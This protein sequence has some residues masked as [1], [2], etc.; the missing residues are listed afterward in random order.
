MFKNTN[1]KES[2]QKVDFLKINYLVIMYK[3]QYSYQK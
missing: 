1:K 2:L 3:I